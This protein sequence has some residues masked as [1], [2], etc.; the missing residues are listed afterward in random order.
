MDHNLAVPYSDQRG[1]I[2]L[3]SIASMFKVQLLLRVQ[4]IIMDHNLAVPCS[5]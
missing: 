1:T 2:T 3:F 4:T 5:G